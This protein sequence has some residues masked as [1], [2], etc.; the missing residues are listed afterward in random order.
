MQQ[1]TRDFNAVAAT[2]DEEPRRVQ[3]VTD[4]SRSITEHIALAPDMDLL[5]FGCGTGLLSLMLQPMVRSVTGVDS[6]PGMLDVFSAKAGQ[7]GLTNVTAQCRDLA[8]G[9]Q[10]EG[11]FHCVVSS[12]AFHHVQDIQPLLREF[13]RVLLPGGCLAIAD[14]DLDGG[15][16]HDDPTGVFHN[17][18]DREWLMQAFAEAGFSAAACVTAA[19]IV[20]PSAEA[21]AREFSVFLA[22]ARTRG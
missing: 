22:T 10:L 14:L 2:W 15:R 16:F 5:D 1:V 11:R 7:L 9:E 17:G 4:I 21:A 8:R 12:M 19:T 13:H 3:L 20:K 18:F 6:S